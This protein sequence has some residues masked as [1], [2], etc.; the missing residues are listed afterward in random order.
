MGADRGAIGIVAIVHPQGR[1][2]I[3]PTLESMISFLAEQGEDVHLFSL[4]T[5]QEATHGFTRHALRAEH[6][7]LG[8]PAARILSRLWFPVWVWLNQRRLRANLMVAV[9]AEGVLGVALARMLVRTR[10]AYLSLHMDTVADRIR[11]RRYGAALRLLFVRHTLRRMEIMITQDSYRRRQ[12]QDAN[13]LGSD[14]IEWFLVPNSHR[15]RAASQE[16]SYYQEKFNLPHGEPVVLVAGSIQSD[17]SH[18]D[19]L[20]ECAAKQDPP[21]YTLVMQSREHLDAGGL[22]KLAAISHSRAL[23]SPDP[24]AARERTR[25]FGSATVGAAIY[26]NEFY[27]NQTF[28]GGASGKM[29]SYLQAGVPVIMLDSPGITEVIR[30]FGCGEILSELDCDEFNDLVRKVVADREGYSAR[31]VQCYNERYEFDHAFRPVYHFVSGGGS[32]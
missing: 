11:R 25:A 30:E 18:T 5:P 21:V 3:T 26:T 29:M 13:G 9:D 32:L 24:V 10:Y 23:L 2:G 7:W 31:A 14:S 1:V 22:R 15:G 16:S 12:L 6:P 27:S 20:A 17:W 4:D 19:F 8:K 28:V